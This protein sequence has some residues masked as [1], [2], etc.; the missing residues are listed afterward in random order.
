AR[1][2][3]SAENLFDLFIAPFSQE[4]EPPPN[5][6]RFTRFLMQL[7]LNGLS[8]IDNGLQQQF[9]ASIPGYSVAPSALPESRF[10]S[11]P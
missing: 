5:P 3:T 4:L 1:S 9:R 6:G 2:R 7:Q 8:H 10:S 11:Y